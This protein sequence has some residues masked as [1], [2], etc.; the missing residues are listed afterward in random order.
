MNGRTILP[1]LAGALIAFLPALAHAEGTFE[2]PL[3]PGVWALQ[4]EIDPDYSYGVGY[5]GSTTLWAKRH[6]SKRDALRLGVGWLHK[7][8]DEDGDAWATGLYSA[9]NPAVLD[10]GSDGDGYTV[11]LQW[12]HHWPV[13][14]RF[15]ALLGAGPGFTYYH[16]EY[17]DQETYPAS[18]YRYTYGRS[19]TTRGVGLHA[20]LGFEWFFASRLSLAGH[21]GGNAAYEWGDDQTHFGRVADLNPYY[22]YGEANRVDIRGVQFDSRRVVLMLSLYL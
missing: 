20:I 1:A 8:V 15:A 19:T 6:L 13:G 18:N 16:R 9:S 4:F 21:A 5:T 11:D 12:V 22:S 3:R 14:D 2:S 17:W 10:A 7:E